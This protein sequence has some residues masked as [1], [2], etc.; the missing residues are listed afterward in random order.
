MTDGGEALRQKRIELD[1]TL[2]EAATRLR[3][4]P[5][6][7]SDLEHGRAQGDWLRLMS[8]LERP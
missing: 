2:R 1:L 4:S 7:L 6:E 5:R 8:E 3:V